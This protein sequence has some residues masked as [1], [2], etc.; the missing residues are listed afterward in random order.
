MALVDDDNGDDDTTAAGV[1][2]V[3]VV[4]LPGATNAFA[5]N[6]PGD[7][8]EV[9]ENRRRNCVPNSNLALTLVALF[10]VP[11]VAVAA[12]T[13][14]GLTLL[15]CF[16]PPDKQLWCS[17]PSLSDGLGD[18]KH[19]STDVGNGKSSNEFGKKTSLS[20]GLAT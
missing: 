3:V 8:S 20:H 17:P 2:A 18:C 13:E 19:F 4:V 16:A 7:V 1:V 11:A 9:R 6:G 5:A 14:E 15:C 10:A 12:V